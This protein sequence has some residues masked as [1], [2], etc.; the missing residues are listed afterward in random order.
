[1]TSIDCDMSGYKFSI[2]RYRMLQ[3]WSSFCKKN[4]KFSESSALQCE[5]SSVLSVLFFIRMY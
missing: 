3:N 2:V 5:I 4:S 1:M